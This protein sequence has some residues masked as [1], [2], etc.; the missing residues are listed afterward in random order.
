MTKLIENQ[1]IS[2][3][4]DRGGNEYS[5]MEF[6]RCQFVSSCISITRDP[7]KRSRVRGVRVLKCEVRGCALE[8]AIVEDVVIDDLKT[9]NLLACWGAVF[10]RVELKGKI[11]NIM[12]NSA[13]ATGIAT[14]EEQQAFDEANAAYYANVEWALD[15]SQ[16]EFQDADIRGIPARL[17]RRDPETQ[18]IVT[19][20]KALEGSWKTLDLSKTWWATSIHFLLNRPNDPDVIL[21]AP[22]RH[23]KFKVLLDGLKMLRDAGV[24]EPN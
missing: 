8:T 19:R 15:I 16:A 5:D 7:A 3:F 20:Q 18:A 11:G 6:R 17:V 22:K 1:E 24:A 9:H 21:V 4:Y 23:R 13:V 10:N 2:C 14:P 12:L